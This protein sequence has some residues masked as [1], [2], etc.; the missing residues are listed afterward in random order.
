MTKQTQAPIRA[1]YDSESLKIRIL[2][3][4][5]PIGEIPAAHI[6]FRAEA[7]AVSTG[8]L[9]EFATGPL[10][11]ALQD[12]Y[13]GVDIGGIERDNPES[14][15][16]LTRD[17]KKGG[18]LTPATVRNSFAGATRADIFKVH[19]EEALAQAL[20]YVEK[21]ATHQRRSVPVYTGPAAQAY[22]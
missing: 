12:A 8:P 4:N 5:E 22:D 17:Y 11:A 19:N 9:G 10:T 15:E 18:E 1:T 2:S 21:Q 6:L 13:H 14:F 16:I 7:S 3:G 20:Q